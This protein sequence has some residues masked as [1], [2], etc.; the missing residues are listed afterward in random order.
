MDVTNRH[1]SQRHPETSS[2][3]TTPVVTERHHQKKPQPL[4]KLRRKTDFALNESLIDPDMLKT[5]APRTLKA[6]STCK[7]WRFTLKQARELHLLT[8]RHFT[9]WLDLT[10]DLNI[11]L[12]KLKKSLGNTFNIYEMPL[13][14]IDLRIS[15]QNGEKVIYK[16]SE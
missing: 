13:D 14:Y 4:R 7:F 10:Q 5:Q 15:G 16:L 6:N 1:G 3:P 12:T 11:Q 9:V 8:E 2:T